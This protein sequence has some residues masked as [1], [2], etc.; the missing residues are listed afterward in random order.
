MCVKT[1]EIAPSAASFCSHF[2]Y[3]KSSIFSSLEKKGTHDTT[4]CLAYVCVC[5]C[6]GNK[7]GSSAV[8][9]KGDRSKTFTVTKP[10]HQVNLP[11]FHTK[12]VLFV[13]GQK[14]CFSH[15]SDS[16]CTALHS[17]SQVSYVRLKFK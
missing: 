2:R 5:V 6:L 17:H 7:S 14:T 16:L 10:L 9:P 4:P 8:K 3:E 15:Q 1:F 11:C 12:C 13:C